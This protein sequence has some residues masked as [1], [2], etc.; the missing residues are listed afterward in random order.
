MRRRVRMM[1]G[2]A[3]PTPQILRHEIVRRA[4]VPRSLH[5]S[6]VKSIF[7]GEF[8]RPTRGVI[9][10]GLVATPFSRNQTLPSFPPVVACATMFF[11]RVR[12]TVYNSR[13][14][15][16]HTNRWKCGEDYLMSIN[17][18]TSPVRGITGCAL[19]NSPQRV[20]KQS[21]CS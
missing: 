4:N 11:L 21:Y 6:L 3:N 18:P 1:T 8:D 20:Y 14:R 19:R 2:R 9:S 13:S 10:S 12:E 7:S 5:F 17:D 16:D 15:E